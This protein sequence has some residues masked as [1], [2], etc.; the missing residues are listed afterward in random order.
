MASAKVL[1]AVEGT[2]E[3]LFKDGASKNLDFASVSHLATFLDKD[4][5]IF[6]LLML[7]CV[8]ETLRDGPTSTRFIELLEEDNTV[9]TGLMRQL[10]AFKMDSEQRGFKAFYCPELKDWKAGW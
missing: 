1:R 10:L 7:A 5:P 4:G 2:L 9:A 3:K 6:R 8:R